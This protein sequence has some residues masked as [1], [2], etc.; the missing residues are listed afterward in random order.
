MRILRFSSMSPSPNLAIRL[1]I[2]HL[3][4]AVYLLWSTAYL[5]LSSSRDETLN[6]AAAVSSGVSAW[7]PM[8]PS[9]R[10]RPVS[11]PEGMFST[12]ERRLL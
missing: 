12:V 3:W 6:S 11:F 1:S 9:C 7:S 2:W 10:I 5:A 4:A 8:L